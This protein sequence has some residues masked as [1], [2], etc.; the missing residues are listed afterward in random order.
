M[1]KPTITTTYAGESAKKYIA[2][3]LLS[4]TT[5]ENGGVTVMPNVKHKSVI[6]KVAASGLIKNTSCDFDDQGTV[7][8][9]ERILQT[10]EFQVNTKFCSKQ[11]V[12]SWESAELGV[13]AFTN[14]PA[15]FSDFIIAHFADQI[16]AS[17]ETNIWTGTNANA[18][19]I[20]G[21]ET[22]WANDADIIDVANPAAVTAANVIA[23]MGE[24]L[25]LCPNTIYGKDDLKLYV[26]K[27]VMKNYI[28][29]LGGYALG[30]G[31]NGYENK[32]QMWYNGQALTFDGIPIFMASGMSTNTMALAQT[33]NLYFGTSVLSDL[34]E[35]RVIDTSDV[36]GDRNARFVAR[37]AYGIQYGIGSEI[38]LYNA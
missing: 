16:A 33:S 21:Y 12:D 26:S 29:A 31:A 35:I 6:Q 5:L 4:G 20:D 34:N 14:M 30:V 38:V 2:A 19:E 27:D 25:D 23:K 3:A 11:F 17:V 22:L 32:G 37:F 18:G 8:I 13:S 9:T 1:S 15:S 36:L 7:A 10:E 28:R 24:T